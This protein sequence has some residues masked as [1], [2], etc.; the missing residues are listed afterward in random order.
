MKDFINDLFVNEF[1]IPAKTLLITE[2][3]VTD[4]LFLIKRGSVRAWCKNKSKEITTD[5]FFENKLVTSVE[6]FM[7]NEKSIYNF[8]TVE[9]CELC[10]V[11][12]AEFDKYLTERAD[13]KDKF[14]QALIKRLII[15]AR[16][17][18]QLLKIK[19][20]DRYKELIE[21]QP[22]II[23][24]VPLNIIASYLGITSVSLSRIRSRQDST[25][26]SV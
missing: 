13:I 14:Y 24:R 23:N 17:T 20:E 4:K 8:E 10:F 18:I 16:R 11:T 26:A 1:S 21:L 7:F 22:N 15:H 9:A 25:I 19:P 5:L 2:G 3:S 12:K 6:S